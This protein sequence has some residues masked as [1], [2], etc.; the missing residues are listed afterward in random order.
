MSSFASEPTKAGS[1][2]SQRAQAVQAKA[3]EDGK[4]TKIDEGDEIKFENEGNEEDTQQM[5]Y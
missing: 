4:Q 2:A 5:E 3:K 1:A